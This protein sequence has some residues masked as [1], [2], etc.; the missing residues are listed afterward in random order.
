DAS[1]TTDGR[2]GTAWRVPGD[3][4]G[5]GLVFHLGQA[6]TIRRVS[7]DNGYDKVDDCNG[8]DRYTENR[9]VLSVSWQFDDQA[10]ITRNLAD[11]RGLQAFDLPAE[12]KATIVT[13]RILATTA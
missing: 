11:V 8:T 13:L 2:L 7:I 10:P 1:N 3:G 4:K 6:T 5:Q 12:V 9:R